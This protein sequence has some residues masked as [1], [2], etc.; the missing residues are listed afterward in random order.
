MNILV[1]GSRHWT[2]RELVGDT[3][4]WAAASW[5][6]PNYDVTV[7]HGDAPGADR[8]AH[9]WVTARRE[10]WKLIAVP[11]DWARYG[12]SAGPRRNQAILTTYTIDLCLAFLL[13]EHACRGTRDMMERCHRAHVP[14]L[15]VSR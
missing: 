14:V 6:S 3:L 2:D 7:I 15:V 11:A 8:C 10:L 12:H 13:P 1:T 4:Q 9:G 5:P